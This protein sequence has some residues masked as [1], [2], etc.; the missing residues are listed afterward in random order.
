LVC[1]WC[2]SPYLFALWDILCHSVSRCFHCV[3]RSFLELL[4]CVTLC[5]TLCYPVE[6]SVLLCGIFSVTVSRGV[7]TVSHGVFLESLPCATLCITLWYPVEY[8]VSQSFTVFSQCH[9]EFF[10]IYYSVLLCV[11]LCGI[12]SVTASHRVFWNYYPVL[13][14]VLLCVTLWNILCYTLILFKNLPKTHSSLK[15]PI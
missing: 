13:L 2:G 1:R 12:F 9:T 6:Y 11:L 10:G 15:K 3:T 8:L 7:F 14:R 5:I 4:P